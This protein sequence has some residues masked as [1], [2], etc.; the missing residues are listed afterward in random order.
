MIKDLLTSFHLQNRYKLAS[1]LISALASFVDSIN[2]IFL[3]GELK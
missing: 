2:Y 3:K 1:V